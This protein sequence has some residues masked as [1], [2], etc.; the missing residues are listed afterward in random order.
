MGRLRILATLVLCLAAASTSAQHSYG[1]YHPDVAG[2]EAGLRAFE[3]K[4]YA[5][6]YE[7]FLESALHA[8]K[9]S[10]AMLAELHWSG[11]G[12]PRDGALAYVW[13]DLA[14]ERGYPL[15]VAKREHYWKEIDD[16]ERERALDIGAGYYG[17]YGDAVAQPRL[18][19]LLRQGHRQATGSR[20]G[21]FAGAQVYRDVWKSN[22]ESGLRSLKGTKVA[23]YYMPQQWV[24][25]DYWRTQDRAWTNA[26]PPVGSVE[27]LPVE[28]ADG[29]GESGE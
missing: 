15:L 14:A 28:S 24:P 10:Q 16:A 5:A 7:A 4:D 19:A 25:K 29:A 17:Q 18:D 12:V 20:V 21:A 2:R 3:K 6:A 11:L 26:Q 8:D 13:A 1:F 9:G 22:E 23:N 27:V